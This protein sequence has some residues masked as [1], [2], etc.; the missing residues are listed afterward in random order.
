MRIHSFDRINEI[1]YSYLP[2]G[3]HTNAPIDIE[4][5]ILGLGVR[6]REDSSLNNGIIGKITFEGEVP[7]ISINPK[8]N[9][10]NS[11]RRFTLAHELGHYV[12]HSK[13]SKREFIDMSETM[14]RSEGSNDF[15]VEANHFAASILMPE[16]ILITEALSIVEDFRKS[17][18]FTQDE[19]IRKLALKF[20]VSIQSMK[21]R[22]INLDILED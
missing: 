12:L 22:L 18:G 6:I 19:F 14:F 3:E 21:Y 17:G 4:S 7:V 2:N 16:G 8:E 20:H 10:Y 5:I 15:E 1:A 13:E 11:R 9:T